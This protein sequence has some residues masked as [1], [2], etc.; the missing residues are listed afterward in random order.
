MVAISGGDTRWR[1]LGARGRGVD[2]TYLASSV[3][4]VCVHLYPQGNNVD[5]LELTLWS[6]AIDKL[7]VIEEMASYVGPVETDWFLPARSAGL[8][9]RGREPAGA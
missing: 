1:W 9:G 3:D 5:E 2:P 4:F 7:V 6:A 8:D